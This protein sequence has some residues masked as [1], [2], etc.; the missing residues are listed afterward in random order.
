ML[1]ADDVIE[2]LGLRPHPCEGGFFAETYR[3]DEIISASGL[4]ER[5]T[6]GKRFGTAVYYLITPETLSY[7]HRLRSDEIFHFYLGDPV[8]MLW[9]LP[10]GSSTTITLGPDL[11]S[12][13]RVQVVVPRGVW[14]GA[15]LNEGGRFALL[16]TTVA[17]GFDY[18]DYE[19]GL[20]EELIARY[21][22]RREVIARLTRG[23]PTAKER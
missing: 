23:D 11:Q 19:A 14:Q 21:P 22:D 16:G 12:G 17:P 1:T 10:D 20:R 5:Y 3:S 2:K 8:T 15:F 6:T 13:Q 18:E 4:S 9:L 7:I